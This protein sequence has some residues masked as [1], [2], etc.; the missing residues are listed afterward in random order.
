MGGAVLS[1]QVKQA[2]SS[3]L[4]ALV[5]LAAIWGFDLSAL[6][7]P[8]VQGI[9]MS[10]AAA[11]ASFLVKPPA[12]SPPTLEEA[13]HV[14]DKANQARERSVL[15]DASPDRLHEDDGFKRPDPQ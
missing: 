8:V 12:K 2:I 3:G 5:A 1:F 11:A 15:R 7:N 6:N 9:I 14:V 13:Y 10:V 4:A